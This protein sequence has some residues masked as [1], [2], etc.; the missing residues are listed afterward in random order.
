MIKQARRT[1]SPDFVYIILLSLLVVFGLIMLTSASSDIAKQE[2]GNS[3]YYLVHQITNGLL[4]GLAGFIFGMFFYYRR[5]EYLAPFI[6][7]FGFILLMLIF[8][9]LGQTLKGGGRWLDF[10]LFTFQPSELLKFVFFIYLAAWIS[11]DLKTRGGSL[12][13]GLIPFVVLVGGAMFFLLAQPATTTAILI[14][15]TSIIM[16]FLAGARIRLL[17]FLVLSASLGLAMFIMIGGSYR[18]D[19]IQTFLHPETTDTL[20]TGYHIGQAKLAIGSG[21]LTGVGFG[22]STTK[23]NFLPEPIGDSIF[24]IIAEELGFIGATIFL[25]VFVAFIWRGFR[26]AKRATDNFGRLVATG[27]TSIVAF[28]AFVNIAAISGLI[29]LTGVPLPF[30]SYGGTALAV[31]L[32][33]SGVVVNISKHS[34]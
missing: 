27:F 4:L 1:S 22:K 11:K 29:P 9:P 3:Y 34:R 30:I 2:T 12:V 8:T 28:Q 18:V 7:I 10:K 26:I 19:R 33:M 20:G 6:L 32:T 14:F 25:F 13:K 23:L 24:A 21:G 31:F 16:Y 5:W 17:V 15:V